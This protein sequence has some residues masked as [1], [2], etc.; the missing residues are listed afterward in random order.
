MKRKHMIGVVA[1]LAWLMAAD[2]RA[3]VPARNEALDA[4]SPK[5]AIRRLFVEGRWREAV[6]A[7][8]LAQKEAPADEDLHFMRAMVA[9]EAGDYAESFRLYSRLLET[10]PD[11]AGLKNNVA[12]LRV[13]SDD[14]AIHN[15]DLALRE[16]QEAVLAASQDYNIWNTLGEIYLVRGNAM[17]AMRLAVLARDMAAMAGEPDLRVYQ[18]LVNRCETQPAPGR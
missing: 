17:R 4:P 11:N 14:P 1:A 7:L 6:D 3:Q 18:D 10:Y 13:K 8:N 12:W 9:M 2:A 16:A 15:L 5:A